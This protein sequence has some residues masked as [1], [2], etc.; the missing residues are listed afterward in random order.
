[1]ACFE[2]AARHVEAHLAQ[3]DEADIHMRPPALAL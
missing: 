2:Q 3:S 1:M